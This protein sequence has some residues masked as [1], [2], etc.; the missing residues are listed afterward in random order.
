MGTSGKAVGLTVWPDRPPL[1]PPAPTH[2]G[3]SFSFYPRVSAGLIF[4]CP[5]DAGHV[6]GPDLQ[7]ESLTR[8]AALERAFGVEGIRFLIFSHSTVE[9]S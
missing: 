4:V 2:R 6:G 1:R 7:F 8:I 9:P 3:L 5:M